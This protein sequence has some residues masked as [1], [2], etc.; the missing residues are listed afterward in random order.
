MIERPSIMTYEE[1]IKYSREAKGLFSL[2]K[3][4]GTGIK[5]HMMR[6]KRLAFK[7]HPERKE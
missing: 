1:K 4:I 6:S 7:G 5:N 3:T 2:F